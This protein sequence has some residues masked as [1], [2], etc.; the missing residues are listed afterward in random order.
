MRV[1]IGNHNLLSMQAQR[2]LSRIMKDAGVSAARLAA[3][4]R[5]VHAGDDPAGS[6]AAARFRA[7]AASQVAAQRNARNLMD[8]L[9]TADGGIASIQNNLIRMR[10]LA[11][12][13]SNGALTDDERAILQLEFA[14]L[15]AEMDNIARKT[16]YNGI[17][18]LVTPP[19]VEPE[20]TPEEPSGYQPPTGGLRDV[21]VQV[22]SDSVVMSI[23]DHA[24]LDGDIVSVDIDGQTI[25]DHYTIPRRYTEPEQETLVTLKQGLNRV[26]VRAENEG[27]V[28]PNTASLAI[29]NVVDGPS[30]QRWDIHEG[31]TAAFTIFFNIEEEAP[32]EE[33]EEAG[34]KAHIGIGNAQDADYFFIQNADMTSEA[35]DLDNLNISEGEGALTAIASLDAALES[36]SSERARFGAVTERLT[37]TEQFLQ[38]SRERTSASFSQVSDADVAE[39]ISR[40]IT[41]QIQAKTGAAMLTQANLLPQLLRSMVG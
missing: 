12:E 5:L 10:A 19:A 32:E 20:E 35:L 6:L 26:T 17:H 21:T 13:A 1:E 41:A 7:Q 39:E 8:L 2:Q 31:E 9:T 30:V 23:W 33:A 38:I 37:N 11:I 16:N 29:S 27:S 15:R 4:S 28:P 25:W 18:P 24:Y 14:L 36:A 34:I 40:F 3:G 22:D